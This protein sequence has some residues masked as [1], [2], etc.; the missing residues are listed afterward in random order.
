MTPRPLRVSTLS[1][2]VI[3]VVLAAGASA[4]SLGGALAAIVS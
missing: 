4:A 3:F 1:Q 2:A